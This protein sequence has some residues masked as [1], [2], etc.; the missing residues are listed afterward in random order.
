MFACWG[1]LMPCEVAPRQASQKG[2]NLL[3]GLYVSAYKEQ[4][5]KGH[6]T[7][8]VF[9]PSRGEVHEHVLGF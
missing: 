5:T 3:S 6:T 8:Q 2:W 4:T 7:P 9:G 1:F